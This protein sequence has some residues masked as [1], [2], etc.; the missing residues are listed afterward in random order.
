MMSEDKEKKIGPDQDWTWILNIV[1][2]L[3][4]VV[5]NS[6]LRTFAGESKSVRDCCKNPVHSIILNK[7]QL[8]CWKGRQ[9][10]FGSYI[11]DIF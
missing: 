10:I 2:M 4:L 5:V 11:W 1:S 6:I 7:L 9:I 8:D 3:Y